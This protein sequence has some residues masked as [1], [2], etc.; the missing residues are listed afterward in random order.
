MARPPD[1]NAFCSREPSMTKQYTEAE[2]ADIAKPFEAHAIDALRR[3]DIGRVGTLLEAMRQGS[4]GLDA[5]S[6]HP[7][8]RKAGKL[9]RDFGEQRAR[10]V[11][12]RI[13]AQLMRTWVEQ[14]ERGDERGAIGDLIAIFREQGG[15]KLAPL[16]ESN[17]TVVLELAPCGSGGRLERQGLPEKHPDWYGGW[18]GGGRPFFPIFKNF[19]GAPQKGR[20]V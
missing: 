17:E 6:G 4:A 3:G 9:R 20:G 18:G 16:Q 2:L 13:G 12:A 14:Y 10:E 15:A 7:L 1:R 19:P 11:L 8:A 5:L